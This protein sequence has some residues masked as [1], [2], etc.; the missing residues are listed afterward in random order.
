M[1]LTGV[2]EWVERR[3]GLVWVSWV[4]G[5]AVVNLIPVAWLGLPQPA[6]HD[7]FSYL[8]GA[9]TLARGRLAN[10]G[11][12]AWENF[13]SLYVQM[14]PTYASIYPP[15]SAATLA[16]GQVV[17]GHA[18]WGLFLVYVALAAVL[19][20][21]LL[22]YVEFRYAMA[23]SLLV[24]GG[25]ACTY[26]THGYWGGA[27]AALLGIVLLG[28]LAREG[29]RAD[30]RLG[31]A[32]GALAFVRP[33][34]GALLVAGSTA[35]FALRRPGVKNW[36]AYLGVLGLSLGGWL[37]YNHAVTGNAWQHPYFRYFSEYIAKPFFLG[38]ETR[39]VKFR[40][41][42]I[43]LMLSNLSAIPDL[44]RLAAWKIFVF[45]FPM[46]PLVGAVVLAAGLW[47]AWRRQRSL[48]VLVGMAGLTVLLSRFAFPH[49][50]A[51]Y[52]GVA[53]LLAAYGFKQLRGRSALA[54]GVLPAG[55]L[56]AALAADAE[57]LVNML[58]GRRDVRLM[59]VIWPA[60]EYPPY[61]LNFTADGFVKTKEAVEL[62]LA[63][64]RGPHLVF[65]KYDASHNPHEEWVY[66]GALP[67]TQEIVWARHYT[68]ESRVRVKAEFRDRVCW[69]LEP[70]AKPYRL[71][72]CE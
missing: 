7:E 66:N 64:R 12:G 23:A 35:L 17:F 54:A 29:M 52:F 44:A 2:G 5:F 70:D 11:L 72:G 14:Q 4:L 61:S 53:A 45:L 38:Q 6:I 43:E 47:F 36:M 32:S 31:A 18:Y 30:L 56:C 26:W 48:W 3:R 10:P 65:V 51:P 49:Y 37:F 62:D 63:S 58:R 19:P 21:A 34:E 16:L 67:Q 55:V 33:F 24:G 20:W 13:E 60:L 39:A 1:W 27:L 25:V 41:I 40:H 69:V 9:D 22:A 15:G 68:A 8:L 59:T 42:E 57:A 28:A 46:R 71:L 50:V